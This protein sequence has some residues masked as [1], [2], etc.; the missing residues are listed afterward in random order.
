MTITNRHHRL[1]AF[2]Y[3]EE[4]DDMDEL[5]ENLMKNDKTSRRLLAMLKALNKFEDNDQNNDKA[6]VWPAVA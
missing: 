5:I 2:T 4:P 6:A 1:Q 3:P